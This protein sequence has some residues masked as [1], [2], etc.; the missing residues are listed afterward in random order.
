[1]HNIIYITLSHCQALVDK[2]KKIYK[3]CYGIEK[4]PKNR[5]SILS[6]HLWIL[7]MTGDRDPSLKTLF[8]FPNLN[9]FLCNVSKMTADRRGDHRHPG[10]RA[11]CPSVPAPLLWLIT[12]PRP[13]VAITDHF[14]KHGEML[15]PPSL[16]H[17][18]S[19]LLPHSLLFAKATVDIPLCPGTHRLNHRSDSSHRKKPSA[20]YF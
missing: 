5:L 18:L 10:C 6:T 2:K 19:V 12:G 1:M 16:S 11:A 3:A 15:S 7:L 4:T 9:I 13:H 17:S 20:K 8:H 14:H